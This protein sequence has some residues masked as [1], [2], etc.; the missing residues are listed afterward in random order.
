MSTI[1]H[2]PRVSIGLPV[3]NGENYLCSIIESIL[4]QTF[5][6]FELIICDNASTDGTE[7][8][9]RG[10]A[11]KDGR[12]RYF[13]N[14]TNIGAAANHN[15]TFELSSGEYFKWCSHDD[16]LAP[17]YLERCVAALDSDQD[18]IAA[19]PI[20]GSIDSDGTLVAVCNTEHLKRA[21]SSRPS[22]R[23]AA[24]GADP[25]P[26]YEVYALIRRKELARTELIA[27]YPQSD[28]TLIAELS[29]IGRFVIVPDVL[30]FNRDHPARFTR[31]ALM[32]RTASWLWWCG[33][34]IG[35]P[36]FFRF[37]RRC[38]N[39]HIQLSL[40]RIIKKHLTEPAER[41]RTY[42]RLFQ[43][44]ISPRLFCVLIAEPVTA[45]HPRI[46]EIAVRLK[47]WLEGRNDRALARR[48]MNHLTQDREEE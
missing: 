4:A 1:E 41:Y 48:S 33:P 31:T 16:L 28:I 34:D 8:I 37:Y 45:L 40:T 13:R 9:C 42:F 30:Y 3:F 29:L 35:M 47:R 22:D 24:L 44:V 18:V 17:I 20:V 38:P 21:G 26:C 15:R 39:W 23:F 7:A 6:S 5:Q 25:R 10:Y 43:H 19:Q 46:F 36:S 14:S 32:D 11:S 27:P 2:E 12:I